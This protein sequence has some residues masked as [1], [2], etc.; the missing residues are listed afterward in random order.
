MTATANG[1][2]IFIN[3]ANTHVT[4]TDT[5]TSSNS[6]GATGSAIMVRNSTV[7]NNAVRIP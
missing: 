3:G 7:S 4:L 6:V 2:G 5:V 1:V